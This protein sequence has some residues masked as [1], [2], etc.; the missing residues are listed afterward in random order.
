MAH[1]DTGKDSAP[2]AGWHI[3]GASSHADRPDVILVSRRDAGHITPAQQQ[4]LGALL[5]AEPPKHPAGQW[6]VEEETYQVL[7]GGTIYDECDT[8]GGVGYLVDRAQA[9]INAGELEG[10]IRTRRI[11]NYL[12]DETREG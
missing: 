4:E 10:E 8:I 7:I 2:D 3:Y 11:V 5:D 6:E 12:R 9:E 1:I